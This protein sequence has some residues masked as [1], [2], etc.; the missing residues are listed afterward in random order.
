MSAF[1]CN[2]YFVQRDFFNMCF[3]SMCSVL[4]KLSEYMYFYISKN[5]TSIVHKGVS[6]LPLPPISKPFPP[7]LKISHPATLLANRSSQVFLT[8]RNATVKLS[9]INTMHVKQQ[10]CWL[11]HFQVHSKVHAR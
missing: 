11:F 2:V 3:I 4:N 1:F 9:L 10:K 7:F 8:K 5:I 6:T